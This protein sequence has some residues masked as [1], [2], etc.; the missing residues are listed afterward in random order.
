MAFP[1]SKILYINVNIPIIVD[2]HIYGTG[3]GGFLTSMI[4]IE[5]HVDLPRGATGPIGPILEPIGPNGSNC[6]SRGVRSEYLRIPIATCLGGG[7][8]GV[9]GG[10]SRPRHF[11]SPSLA[12]QLLL[13]A[14]ILSLYCKLCGPRVYSVCFQYQ[15]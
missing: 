3:G 6:F 11:F 5:D 7:G 14:Y 4:F 2:T 8:G 1:L 15:I 9:V 12:S 10:A 13:S